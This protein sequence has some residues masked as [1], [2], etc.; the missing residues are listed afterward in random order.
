MAAVE[1][2]HRRDPNPKEYQRFLDS[3]C[4]WHD[5]GNQKTKDCYSLKGYA[6]EILNE[7]RQRMHEKL[8]MRD[9]PD[10]ERNVKSAGEMEKISVPICG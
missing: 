3:P 6:K 8:G 2:P 10:T 1:Q 7:A 9:L 4:I 5:K